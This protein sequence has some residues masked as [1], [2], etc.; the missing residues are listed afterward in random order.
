M[1]DR[2]AGRQEEKHAEGGGEAT[3]QE[4]LKEGKVDEKKPERLDKK[5]KRGRGD[6]RFVKVREGRI[7][8]I[9]NG[10]W[11]NRKGG[12]GNVEQSQAR[13]LC[14]LTRRNA[15]ARR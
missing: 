13:L 3:K 9:I 7:R 11:I 10:E 1:T 12:T 5:G 2:P 15:V 4:R 14:S 8:M 6:E